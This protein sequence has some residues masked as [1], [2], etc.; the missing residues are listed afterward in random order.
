MNP[1][2][3]GEKRPRRLDML[4]RFNPF[5]EFERTLFPTLESL[6]KDQR[7]DA[8]VAGRADGAA[9]FAP[10]ADVVETEQGLELRV[11]LPGHDPRSIEVKF[12]GDT[13][14]LRSER[15]SE[16]TAETGRYVRAERRYGV[17]ARSFVLPST[18]DGSKA[19]AR[20]EHGVLTV[21]LPKKEEAKPRTVE[22]KV[23]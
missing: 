20:L 18:F 22:I 21:V 17:F 4:T 11:D 19:E 8:A 5:G 15:K 9:W 10:A 7:G 23:R 6:F 12:E 13:L 3:L 16:R 14:T 1:L 2:S